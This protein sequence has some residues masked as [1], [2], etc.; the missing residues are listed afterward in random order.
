MVRIKRD[1]PVLIYRELRIITLLFFCF[2]HHLSMK[3]MIIILCSTLLIA[4]TTNLSSDW[5]VEIVWTRNGIEIVRGMWVCIDHTTILTSAHIVRDDTINYI[6][7]STDHRWSSVIG[8]VMERDITTDMAYLGIKSEVWKNNTLCK[9][10]RTYIWKIDTWLIWNTISIPVFRSGA[11]ETLTGTI[12]SLTG[13][14]LGYDTLGRVQLMT[15]ILM[16]DIPLQPWDSG[17]PILDG[18]GRV[19]DVVHVE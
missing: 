3:Y 13:T 10:Y 12:T 9:D 2:S 19:L 4:C 14:I 1:F 11:I 15:W 18:Q 5:V 8:T 6:L 16:T 17:A 7:R